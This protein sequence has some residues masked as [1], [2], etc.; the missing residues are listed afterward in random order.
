[1][2]MCEG[3][4]GRRHMTPKTVFSALAYYHDNKAESDA[5]R[6]ENSC[7]RWKQRTVSPGRRPFAL[8][9]HFPYTLP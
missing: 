4:K 3:W 2:I 9:P 5:V 7:E 1:M 6:E 8:R